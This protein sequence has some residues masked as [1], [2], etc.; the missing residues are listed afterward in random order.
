[1][2]LSKEELFAKCKDWTLFDDVLPRNVLDGTPYFKLSI[3]GF[4]RWGPGFVGQDEFRKFRAVMRDFKE[5]LS[6]IITS[7]PVRFVPYDRF[8]SADSI[9]KITD[10]EQVVYLH[11]MEFTGYL[12]KS[13]VDN[14]ISFMQSAI[15]KAFPD[16]QY[17]V[18]LTEFYP[19]ASLSDEEYRKL[20][21]KHADEITERMI[22]LCEWFLSGP[23]SSGIKASNV[24]AITEWDQAGL[25]FIKYGGRIPRKGDIPGCLSSSDPDWAV[26]EKIVSK[27]VS[28]GKFNDIINAVEEL[29]P[30]KEGL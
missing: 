28:E 25:S 26:V 27:A 22:I 5:N 29:T 15:D 18:R 24:R 7:Q 11:P 9:V 19:T 12:P 17:Q 2:S 23:G 20:I 14:I 21:M 10:E 4:Y 16:K 3:P 1:M 30:R 13:D 6:D 8:G